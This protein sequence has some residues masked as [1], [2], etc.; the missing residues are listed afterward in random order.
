MIVRRLFADVRPLKESPEFRRLW[1]GMA[2]SSL[3]SQM[4]VVAML[5]QVY[6]M[7]NDTLAVGGLALCRVVPAVAFALLGG[8]VGDAVDRRRLVLLAT[9]T[10]ALLSTVLVVQALAGWDRLWPLYLV[11]AAQSAVAAVNVPARRTFL[12]RLLSE[13][14]VPAGAA[15][16]TITVH[17]GVICGP[18][19]GGVVSAAWGVEVCYVLDVVTYAVILYSVAKLPPMRPRGDTARPGFRAVKEA[20]HLV[21]KTPVLRGAFLVDLSVTVL[22]VPTALLPAL[23]AV[24]FD[25][26]EQTLGLLLSATGVGGL[27]GTLFSGPV[28]RVARPGRAMAF[29]GVA[30]GVVMAIFAVTSGLWIALGLLVLAGSLDALMVIFRTTIVQ[31]VT[32]DNYLGRVGSIEYLVGVG[33]PQTG[34]ARA[35]ALG[36]VVSPEYGILIGAI[37]AVTAVTLAAVMTPSFVRNRTTIDSETSS[38]GSLVRR[39]Q[40]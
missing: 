13:E 1:I 39:Q 15:L 3:G 20:L 19:L 21:R 14:R 7:T 2:L 22:G 11:V 36:S 35:G 30:W 29:G 28:G 40:R 32:P 4:S 12:R 17:F 16:S 34:N 33:G 24:R 27:L 23:T 18:A 8:S 6:A 25:G 26:G 5:I 9:C 31:T 38:A 10:Q 37:S